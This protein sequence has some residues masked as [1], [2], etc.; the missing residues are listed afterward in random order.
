MYLISPRFCHRFVG[1]LE[2]QAVYTYTVLLEC[3]DDGKLPQFALMKAPKQAIEYY[4]MPPDATFRDMILA[5]RA[6]EACHR[7]TNHHFADINP[8]D[9]VSSHEVELKEDG[10]YTYSRAIEDKKE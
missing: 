5:I 3:I 10:K 4:D 2:E 6:D 7:E 8:R 1:Y 9:E